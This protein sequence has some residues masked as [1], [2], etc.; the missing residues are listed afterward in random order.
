MTKITTNNCPTFEYPEPRYFVDYFDEEEVRWVR[1]PMMSLNA[2]KN[3]IIYVLVK[4]NASKITINLEE[5]LYKEAMKWDENMRQIGLGYTRR[6]EMFR[7]DYQER[8]E[9]M[10]EEVGFTK[11]AE[12]SDGTWGAYK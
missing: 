1:N 7:Q 12:E 9:L 8:H 10:M 2:M 5:S 11:Y 6:A 3:I 4:K